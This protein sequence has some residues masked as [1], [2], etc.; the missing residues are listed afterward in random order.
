MGANAPAI[1]TL[2][3][4]ACITDTVTRPS[5]FGA[6]L[7]PDSLEDMFLHSDSSGDYLDATTPTTA[8]PQFENSPALNFKHGNPWKA[9]GTW[10][11][12]LP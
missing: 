5:V 12:V 8:T 7:T 3:A 6:E 11:L 2:S 1:A 4:C 9:I 10:S